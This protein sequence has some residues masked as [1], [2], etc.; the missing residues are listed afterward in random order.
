MK[1]S[2]LFTAV[3]V[4]LFA[5]CKKNENQNL[6]SSDGK[7]NAYSHLPKFKTSEVLVG[8]KTFSIKQNLLSSLR[9]VKSEPI[10]G[11]NGQVP[12]RSGGST[13][14]G[15][16]IT[17]ETDEQVVLDSYQRLVYPGS[18]IKGRSVANMS[19]DPVIGYEKLPITV[20]VSIPAVNGMVSKIIDNPNLSTTRTAI[21]EILNQNITGD[22]LSSFS[23]ELNKFTTYD[24]LKL[25]FGAN[26]N[27]GTI[28]KAAFK[29]STSQVSLK[30]GLVAKF[31][32]RNFTLD[33]DIPTNGQLLANNVDPATL[34]DYSPV[35]ISSVTYGRMGIMAIE[36]NY[37][38]NDVYTA[39]NATLSLIKGGG[40]VSITSDQKRI[41][42]ES[43]INIYARGGEGQEVVKSIKGYDEFV[44][45][46]ISG[47]K[48]SVNTPGV[49]IFF[50]LNYL[51]DHTLFKT[52]FNVSQIDT[53]RV[54]SGST[55]PNRPR[56]GNEGSGGG[57]NPHRGGRG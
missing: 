40:G 53:V 19:F 21:N 2:L 26:V 3:A 9:I 20:S 23:F 55:D 56:P 35:Y 8:D 7:I 49:P 22:Q 25:S 50:S 47:G 48:F 33:M 34:G 5:S 51:S 4:I 57:T 13:S 15:T 44:N 37:E 39:F 30:T 18:L 45:Y 32:Q 10:P 27:I 52:L 41:I 14:I 17:V 11:N 43:Q 54:H 38:Y 6:Q 36:S 16:R 31:I 46:I 24:E 1:K 12:S 42:D 29:D 28:F